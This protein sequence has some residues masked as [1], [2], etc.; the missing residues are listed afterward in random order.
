[1][2]VV[3]GKGAESRM[4]TSHAR[5]SQT[6]VRCAPFAKVCHRGQEAPARESLLGRRHSSWQSPAL[7][8]S[9]PHTQVPARAPPPHRFPKPETYKDLIRWFR[10]AEVAVHPFIPA[11]AAQGACSFCLGVNPTQ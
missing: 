6:A 11:P 2:T 1:M 5:H 10:V 9:W 8:H 7:V 3:Q 4:G